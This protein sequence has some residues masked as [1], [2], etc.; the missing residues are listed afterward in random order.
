MWIYMFSLAVSKAMRV[1][2]YDTCVMAHQQPSQQTLT[3]THTKAH[4]IDMPCTNTASG[5][6]VFY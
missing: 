5:T 6:L 4:Y 3:P 2:G 1:K